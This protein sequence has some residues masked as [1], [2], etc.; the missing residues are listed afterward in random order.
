VDAC[1]LE[2]SQMGWQPGRAGLWRVGVA[3]TQ[4]TWAQ[5]YAS[6]DRGGYEWRKRGVYRFYAIMH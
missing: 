5:G 3:E 1:C 4:G 6:R 2:R